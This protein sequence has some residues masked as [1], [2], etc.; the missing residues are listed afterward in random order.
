MLENGEVYIEVKEGQ[1]EM[2]NGPI[3]AE[4]RGE[5]GEANRECSTLGSLCPHGEAMQV[6]Y[7]VGIRQT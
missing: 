4:E 5:M 1:W 2:G 6:A 7:L 3:R